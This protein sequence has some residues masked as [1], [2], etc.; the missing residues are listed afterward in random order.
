MFNFVVCLSF[1]I[2]LLVNAYT[3]LKYYYSHGNK[4]KQLKSK[5]NVTSNIIVVNFMYQ[6]NCSVY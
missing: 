5:K 4:K 6:N 3:F 2:N 1:D